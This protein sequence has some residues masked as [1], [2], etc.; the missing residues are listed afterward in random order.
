MNHERK[1][2]TCSTWDWPQKFRAVEHEGRVILVCPKCAEAHPVRSAMT[3]EEIIALKHRVKEGADLDNPQTW[4]K[5]H[6]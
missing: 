2:P 5:D 3:V 1:C 6:A 4:R